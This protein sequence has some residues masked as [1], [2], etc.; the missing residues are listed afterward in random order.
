MATPNLKIDDFVIVIDDLL[1]PCE[2]RL[3]RVEKLYNG[4]DHNVRVV[5]VRTA[6]GVITRPI[7][8]LCYL[9][10][11]NVSNTTNSNIIQ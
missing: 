4:S 6:T 10:Y 3:G 9:P 7:T 2:W 11:N 5:D 1:P 8:K